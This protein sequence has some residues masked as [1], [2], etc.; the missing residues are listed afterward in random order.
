MSIK[1]KIFAYL[2]SFVTL[3]L[4][5][6]WLFQIVYLDV[7]YKRIKSKEIDDAMSDVT[8]IINGD[9][10]EDEVNQIAKKY[11]ISILIADTLG[12][13]EYS[14]N[15]NFNGT[16]SKFNSTQIIYYYQAALI[17]GGSV[18]INVNEDL[19]PIPDR[20][21]RKFDSNIKMPDLSQTQSV[22]L[23]NNV[24]KNN[25]E[26]M[27]IIMNSTIMPVDATVHTLRVQLVYISVIMVAISLFI[28]WLISRRVSSSIIKVNE[29]AKELSKGNFNVK[30]EGNDYREI[31]E[32]SDTLNQS[33]EEL[34]KTEALQR[35]LIANVSHD[36]RT[37]LT[38][39]TAYSELMRDLPG[40]NN[41]ENVQV[42]IDEANRL[43]NLVNDLLDISKIQSGVSKLEIKKYDITQSIQS[44]INRYGKLTLQDG[45]K[46]NFIYDGNIEVEADEYKM[47]QVIYNLINN[48]INYTG[49]DKV[50][51]VKQIINGEI[52]RIEV[53]DTGQG[54]AKEE[55]KN[56]WERYYKIDKEHKRAI[57]GTG[58][59]LSI[60]KNILELHHARYGVDS[61]L[62]KGST[63][64]FELKVNF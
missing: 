29:S 63:F 57:M 9:N 39:I 31:S 52:V 56:V 49:E 60:V 42:I 2:L 22:I 51:R 26:K 34:S 33:A 24:E 50:V 58:L 11:D 53:T 61:T 16:I 17:N 64:W 40:E 46:I 27:V 32:L 15:E 55:L 30:F 14:S 7:F 6:L 37:P 19:M 45:Y 8:S 21:G 13:A 35:E 3:L 28:G 41:P 1:W 38:M 23:V 10:I 25:G 48:A 59:G 43:K 5:I 47:Y 4:V 44:V 54:I 18:K 20:A 62:G 36:L 12:N